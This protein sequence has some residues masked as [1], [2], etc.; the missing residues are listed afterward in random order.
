MMFDYFNSLEQGLIK[1]INEQPNEPNPRKK[2][3]L[4]VA[5]LGKKLY[6]EDNSIAWCGVTAPFDLLS[7]MGI[8]SCFVEFIGSML[9]STGAIEQLL[10]EAEHAGYASDTCG[11]HRSVIGAA[12]KGLM[13]V[14]DILI[15]TSSP[16]SGGIAAIE[17]LSRIY[18]KPLFI[19]TIPQENSQSAI[20]YLANQI[21]E[22]VAFVTYHTGKK[23]SHDALMASIYHSNKVR[24]I[25]CDV[26]ELAQTVPSPA[27]SNRLKDLVI[28]M[29]LFSGSSFAVEV[30]QAYKDEF[31]YRINNHISGIKDEKIRLMWIQNRIQYKNSLIRL[32]E[33]EF[34]AVIV[35]DELNDIIWPPIDPDNPFE[36]LAQR[37]I[38]IPFNGPVTRR[39]HHLQHLAKAYQI[40]GAI[41]P[42]HWGCRQ[43]TG[44]RGLIA[45]GFKKIGIPVLN[46]EVDCVDPRNFAFGQLKTR[47]EAFIEM[48]T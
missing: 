36:G 15:A 33:D 18:Q 38:S 21:K 4:A 17:N 41:N 24:D 6:S 34:N 45:E 27:D 26:F 1:K 48:I 37:A 30:A 29:A 16:C 20:T 7:A 14:P 47:L 44:S 40:H 11:Y 12:Q 32:L 42:C 43:G 9:A 5:Q 2:Y 19:L 10:L 8:T 25:L 28:V 22:M 31:T 39:I 23:L 46:L 35:I 13:P 3:A